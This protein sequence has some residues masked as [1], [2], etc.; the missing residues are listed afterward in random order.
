MTFLPAAGGSLLVAGEP[1][2]SAAEAALGLVPGTLAGALLAVADS[3]EAMVAVKEIGSGRYVHLNARMAEWLAGAQTPPAALLGHTDA[4]LLDAD[5]C[6]LLRTAEQAAAAETSLHRSV[7]RVEHGGARREFIVVRQPLPAADG[8]AVRLLLGVWT[9]TTHERQKDAQLERALA[10]IESQQQAMLPVQEELPAQPG[11]RDR[12]TGLYHARP[13]RRP[14]AP[15]DRP[16]AARAPRVRARRDRARPAGRRGAGA[17]CGRARARARSAGPAAAQQHARDGRVV[18]RR[19]RP[20]RDPAVGRRPGHRACAHGRAAPPVRDADRRLRGTDLGFSVSMGV[21]S[22]PHTAPPSQNCSTPPRPRSREA[23]RRGG[24]HV[25]LASIRF[26]AVE[27]AAAAPA[28]R[29]AGQALAQH[30]GGEHVSSSANTRLNCAHVERVRRARAQRRR[31]HA[32][33]ATI[34]SAGR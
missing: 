13:L 5:A 16:V 24:N 8:A 32:G 11:L 23:Q 28:Q 10:Q 19:R 12:A 29:S 14:A 31:Q 1:V 18:P 22:F 7:H 25:T 2:A 4:A 20:L 6:A 26:E 3:L 33:A 9:E 17:R 21:A 27:R 15:R 34:S 30:V